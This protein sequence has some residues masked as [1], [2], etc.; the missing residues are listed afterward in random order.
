MTAACGGRT[1]SNSLC[2]R[3]PGLARGA[4]V[5]KPSQAD[6]PVA[7]GRNDAWPSRRR[8][9]KRDAKL[10]PT[11]GPN[12]PESS[13]RRKVPQRDRERHATLT[14]DTTLVAEGGASAR[15]IGGAARRPRLHTV[16]GAPSGASRGR[17]RR[18]RV[19]GRPLPSPLPRRRPGA[20]SSYTELPAESTGKGRSW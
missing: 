14:A 15:E 18:P 7:A 12:A 8:Q 6:P 16:L 10:N 1:A 20:P 11:P 19:D 3:S 4:E 17:A 5:P 2:P 13:E 9:R